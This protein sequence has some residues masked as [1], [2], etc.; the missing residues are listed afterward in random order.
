[1]LLVLNTKRVNKNKH[2]NLNK[3]AKFD[4]DDAFLPLLLRPVDSNPELWEVIQKRLRQILFSTK[5]D[6]IISSKNREPT[7]S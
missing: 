5:R 1:M 7:L 2:W 6:I 4:Q 3:K